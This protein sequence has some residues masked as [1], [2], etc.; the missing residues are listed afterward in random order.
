MDTDPWI[1][2]LTLGTRFLIHVGRQTQILLTFKFKPLMLPSHDED[3]NIKLR[4]TPCGSLIVV[5]TVV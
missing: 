1:H 4:W 5:F 3:G 2:L